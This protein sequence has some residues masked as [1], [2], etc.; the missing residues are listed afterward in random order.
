MAPA[1]T[2]ALIW[3]LR[4]STAA[5]WSQINNDV[6]PRLRA[7]DQH[8]ALDR[9]VDRIGMIGDGPSHQPGLA[10]VAHPRSACPSHRH[11]AGFGQ[12]QQ[13]F[14]RRVPADIETAAGKGN[15]RSRADWSLWQVRRLVGLGRNAWRAERPGAE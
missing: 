2:S 1:L 9:R 12:F 3:L 15:Q 11:V 14:A 8:V 10:A 5:L 6:V 7:A 13:A 4:S